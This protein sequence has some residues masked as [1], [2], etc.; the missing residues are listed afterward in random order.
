MKAD[1][2][3]G[4]FTTADKRTLTSIPTHAKKAKILTNQPASSY[5]IVEENSTKTIIITNPDK[6]WSL[7]NYLVIQV[8]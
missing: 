5:E 8:D 7:S 3:Q 6:F 1:F 4:Y 2:E